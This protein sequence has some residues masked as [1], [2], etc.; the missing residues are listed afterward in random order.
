MIA[1]TEKATG[2]RAFIG[3]G[4]AFLG[5]QPVFAASGK[6]IIDLDDREAPGLAPFGL[7]AVRRAQDWWPI[8][9]DALASAGYTPPP[10]VTLA[11]ST[12]AP[13]GWAGPAHPTL[14]YLNAM[15]TSARPNHFNYIAHELVH[16][17]QSYPGPVKQ[18]LFEGIADYVRYYVLFPQDPERFLKPGPGDYRRGYNWAAALLDWVERSRG[19]GSVRKINAA[20]R[21]GQDGEAVLRE[22]AG[23]SLDDAWAKVETDL[24]EGS[25]APRP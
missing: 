17:V 13:S 5:A 8:I 25:P 23:M 6:V 16:V 1:R 15:F 18:W 21:Q 14:L 10:K 9:N 4:V 19:V 3:G 7:E 20:L 12:T 24:V 11:F 2:R 22:L